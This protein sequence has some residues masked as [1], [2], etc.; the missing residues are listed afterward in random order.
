M[1]A[2]G[3]PRFRIHQLKAFVSVASTGSIRA[4]ARAL[5]L[6]PAAVTKAI[7]ELEGDA[8]CALVRRENN[9]IRFSP[10]G[11]ALLVH[12]RVVVAQ[13]ERAEEE[14]AALTGAAPTV[15]RVGIAAWIAMSWLGEVVELFEQRMPRVRLDLF[16]GVLTVSI[17]RLRDGT[18]DLCIGRSVPAQL[19]GEFAHEPLFRTTS[20]VVARRGHPLAACRSLEELRNAAWILNWVPAYE[21]DAPFDLSDPFQRFLHEHRPKAHV[22]H[23]LIIAISLVRDTDMLALMPWPLVEAVA[24]REGFCTLPL[25]E[26]L[27][28]SDCSLI[29]RRGVP[30]GE[31][32]KCFMECFRI[33]TQRAAYSASR[34]ERRVFDSLEAISP[35]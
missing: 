9:G 27:N 18:L 6:S 5:G 15:L 34:S 32:A 29:T 23:S 16:E 25:N 33:V 1:P 19:H 26:T 22:A 13:L 20:A 3:G 8:G 35:A 21:S 2:P 31:A 10:A 17:P 28:D 7:R 30:L 4:A 11:Q 14:L 12:A 24:H